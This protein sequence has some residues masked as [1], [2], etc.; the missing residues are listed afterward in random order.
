MGKGKRI[1]AKLHSFFSLAWR[2][3]A[4]LLS[5]ICFHLKVDVAWCV[6]KDD[7]SCADLGGTAQDTPA[8]KRGTINEKL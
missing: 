1:L 3:T 6:R 4:M 2:S 8:K 7:S 5:G